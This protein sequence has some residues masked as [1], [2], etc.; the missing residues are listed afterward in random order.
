V[1]QFEV[2]EHRML[3]EYGVELIKT[4]VSYYCARWLPNE[5]DDIDSPASLAALRR[6]LAGEFG[7]AVGTVVI[8]LVLGTLGYL[9][10]RL[11]GR[12]WVIFSLL[13]PYFLWVSFA[14]LLQVSLLILN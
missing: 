13:L 7:L 8:F 6:S 14:T 5:R 10:Y 11:Y 1:L 2:V 3:T 9:L 4:P 12:G